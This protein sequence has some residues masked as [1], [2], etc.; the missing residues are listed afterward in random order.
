MGTTYQSETL[1]PL[2]L[3]NGF[4]KCFSYL[5]EGSRPIYDLG[6][7]LRSKYSHL[8]PEDGVYRVRDMRILSSGSARTIM[9]LQSFMA[10]F[11]PGPLKEKD[12]FPLGWQPFGFDVDYDG[13]VRDCFNR[14]LYFY[15]KN[16]HPSRCFS[17]NY[18]P[19]HAQSTLKDSFSALK[20]PHIQQ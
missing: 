14:V 19:N 3:K 17:L 6:V 18:I 10:G 4:L 12:F 20:N 2:I 11:I 16:F 1:L 8:F 9:S 7:L 13:T 15:S 5:Q